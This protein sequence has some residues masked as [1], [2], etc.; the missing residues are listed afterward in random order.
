[1]IDERNVEIVVTAISFPRQQTVA[2]GI[3]DRLSELGRPLP[4]ILLLG[5]APEFHLGIKKRA[6]GWMQRWGMEWLH[7]FASEP[8][9]LFHRYFVEDVRF[10]RIV[11]REWKRQRA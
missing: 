9:R 2:F 3:L 10:V 11:W 7:R 1:M 4:L 6:P 8:R 5:A